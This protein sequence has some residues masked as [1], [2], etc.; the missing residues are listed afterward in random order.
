M[1]KG[2]PRRGG[3]VVSGG[4]LRKTFTG[5]FLAGMGRRLDGLRSEG[6]ELG[7]AKTEETGVRWDHQFA[8]TS[9]VLIPRKY[10]SALSSQL[11]RGDGK[12]GRIARSV[13][14][15]PAHKHTFERV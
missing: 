10:L 14:P 9:N 12:G 4:S 8:N 15:A 5:N 6:W 3:V 1:E 13:C 7:G 2:R 11:V